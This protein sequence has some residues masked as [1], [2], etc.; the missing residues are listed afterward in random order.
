MSLK[1]DV[2]SNPKAKPI[3]LKD[4][5]DPPVLQTPE[6]FLNFTEIK[7]EHSGWYKCIA[8][9]MLGRFSSIGYF[10]NVRELRFVSHEVSDLEKNVSDDMEVT[11]EPE[12]DVGELSSTGRQV[13]VSLGGAVQ[14]ACPPGKF[15]KVTFIGFRK[16]EL[17]ENCYYHLPLHYTPH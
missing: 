5:G 8:R 10:L 6:G 17:V 4:D 7:R 14:L 1:C 12:F 11:Q 3:W 9:H 2:D 16:P 13:E 15:L